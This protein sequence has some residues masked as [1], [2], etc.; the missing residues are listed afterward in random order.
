MSVS[1]KSSVVSDGHAAVRVAR[2][3]RQA[4]ETG[5]VIERRDRRARGAQQGGQLPPSL[6]EA[7]P[8]LGERRQAE[9]DA[10][11]QQGRVL[12]GA[13]TEQDEADR[14]VCGPE[15]RRRPEQDADE[16]V[17]QRLVEPP[18]HRAGK[19]GQRPWPG[20]TAGGKR[21]QPGDQR[22]VEGDQAPGVDD[23]GQPRHPYER[24]R[25]QRIQ[26]HVRHVPTSIG[27]LQFGR[28]PRLQFEA[29]VGVGP[30]SRERLDVGR[31]HG[32]AAA[33][34]QL[35]RHGDV[36]AGVADASRLAERQH[37]GQPEHGCGD[38]PA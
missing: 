18:H 36:L 24:D 32:G 11:D 30:C 21:E 13:D 22:H 28:T 31:R 26:P 15:Q 37:R 35:T 14:P 19:Q 3:R 20:A 2:E 33:V 12:P 34:G 4:V 7:T 27:S 25:E 1:G 16:Q 5:Q 10:A 29:G 8:I 23:A 38:E 17:G 6:R 9:D